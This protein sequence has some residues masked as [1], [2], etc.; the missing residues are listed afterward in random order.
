[1]KN[2][3]NS[4][5]SSNHPG[6]KQLV[7]QGIPDICTVRSIF[8]KF[9][10]SNFYSITVWS[11]APQTTLCMGSLRAEIRTRDHHTA[12]IK[13]EANQKVKVSMVAN[14]SVM[15]MVEASPKE[16][17]HILPYYSSGFKNDST[18]IT[19]KSNILLQYTVQYY[20]C[21]FSAKYLKQCTWHTR[22]PPFVHSFSERGG[23]GIWHQI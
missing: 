17:T 1:M 10:T 5:L 20:F 4:S 14:H 12:L 7:W 2:R 15:F 8:K 6:A 13:L 22:T 21:C 3:L 19:N 18:T 23:G 9:F 16:W 11:A